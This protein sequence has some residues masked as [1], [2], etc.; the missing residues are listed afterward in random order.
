MA[1]I[2]SAILVAIFVA[3]VAIGSIDGK[4]I[5][6]NVQEM[7]LL[8]AASISFVVAILNREA[9]EEKKTENKQ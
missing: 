4:P 9:N 3:N 1:I 5:L 2:I 8:F 6:G 7:L